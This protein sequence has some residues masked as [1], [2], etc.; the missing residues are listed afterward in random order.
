MI[1]PQSLKVTDPLA[2]KAVTIVIKIL[3]TAEVGQDSGVSA[4]ARLSP[5]SAA[6]SL[7]RPVTIAI[8]LE[9]EVP[10]FVSVSLSELDNLVAVGWQT[11]GRYYQ[12]NGSNVPSEEVAAQTLSIPDTSSV[13]QDPNQTKKSNLSLF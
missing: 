9:N 6:P 4:E 11:F 10:V 12:G 1:Q 13:E 7:D 3:P 8:G 2:N 5:R